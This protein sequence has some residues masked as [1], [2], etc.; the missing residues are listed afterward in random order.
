MTADDVA[1]TVPALNPATAYPAPADAPALRWGILAPGGI[2]RR[3]AREIPEYTAST[4]GA[5]GSRDLGR[6]Q[7]FAQELGVP[8]AYGSYQ[9]LVADPEIDV[10][11]VASPHSEHRDHAILALEAGKP[12]LVEKAFTRNA[13]EARE[14]FDVAASR[15][16]FAME[17]MW[18]RFLPH[19]R[20][21]VDGVRSGIVGEV[22]AVD[23][24]HGQALVGANPRLWLPELA[25][26]ALLDLGVY[27]VSFAHAL[28][29]APDSVHAFGPLTELGVDAA[30]TIVLRYGA[31]TVAIAQ[32][33]L[34]TRLANTATIAGTLGR[35]DLADT[36]YFPTEVRVTLHEGA[37]ATLE[38]RCAGGF[39][40]QAA[41]AARCIAAGQL[42]SPVITWQDTVEVMEIMDEVRAQLGVRYPGE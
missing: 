36:F 5:V 1:E 31:R 9:E 25:G 4:I 38:G 33:N 12:V 26:G 2:A 19:Y 7:A 29:G 15:N 3:F 21:V 27:P 24:L 42:S 23:A 20:A 39:Q 30:E 13:A 18:S 40:Y 17:A 16:L 35:V 28:L 34:E 14:V 32:A 6:A 22:L 11:Y 8:R 10:V 37:T 41:E